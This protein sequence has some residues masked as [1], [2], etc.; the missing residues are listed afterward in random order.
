MDKNA[1]DQIKRVDKHQKIKIVTGTG[2][3]AHCSGCSPKGSCPFS[4]SIC[5]LTAQLQKSE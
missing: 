1:E 2:P 5:P 4:Q 3:N